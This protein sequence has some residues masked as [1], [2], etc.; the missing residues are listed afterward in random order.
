MVESV[1]AVLQRKLS[2]SA[3]GV[4]TKTDGALMVAELLNRTSRD[5]ERTILGNMEENSPETADRIKRYMFTFEALTLVDDRGMQRLMRD[6]DTKVLTV[7]LKGA[8]ERVRDKIL[9][10]MSERQR[11][12]IT[13]D[14]EVMGPVRIRDVDEA[15]QQILTAARDLDDAGEIIIQGRGRETEVI[16]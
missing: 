14:L 13:E 1:R 4:A 15:Q 8:S 7:A 16:A 10:N 2:P 3:S 5:I 12:M 11:E 6:V 9:A